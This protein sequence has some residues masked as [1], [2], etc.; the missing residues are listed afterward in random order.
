VL[1]GEVGMEEHPWEELQP[2]LSL[3]LSSSEMSAK[4][5]VNRR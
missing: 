1:Q 2:G 4:E 5:T 3:G